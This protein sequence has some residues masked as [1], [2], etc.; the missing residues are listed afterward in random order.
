LLICGFHLLSFAALKGVA[1]F[2]F[3]IPPEE[4]T[5]GL[6]RGIAFA[7]AAMTLTLLPTWIVMKYMRP[8]VDK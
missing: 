1:L 2:G 5:E 8:L 4:L 3:G 7:F 6:F